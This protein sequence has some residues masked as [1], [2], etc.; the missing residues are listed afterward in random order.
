[1]LKYGIPL[2]FGDSF[3]VLLF[4]YVAITLHLVALDG[5]SLAVDLTAPSLVAPGQDENKEK[6]PPKDFQV[7]TVWGLHNSPSIWNTRPQ[8]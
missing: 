8:V 6:T 2:L 5:V 1:M 3:P 4:W 7:L